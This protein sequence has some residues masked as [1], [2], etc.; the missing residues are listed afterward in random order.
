M[1][2]Q[3]TRFM[4]GNTGVRG[5]RVQLGASWQAVLQ[6][7][8]AGPHGRNLLGQAL[9]AMSLLAA[10]LK[11][12]GHMILQIRGQGPL[13]L[14]VAQA[15]AE[16]T[17][18]GLVRGD[19]PADHSESLNQQFGADHLVITID[20]G[21]QAQPYQGIVPLQ[22]SNLQQAL[23]AY[24]DRSEQLPTQLWL[25]ADEKTAAGFLLQKM[26]GVASDPDGWNRLVTLA[27]SLQSDE[28][29]NL[30]T[31]TLLTRLYHQE[32]VRTFDPEPL[33]FQCGCSRDKSREIIRTL[34]QAEAE[35]I[36]KEQGEIGIHC[37]FCDADYRFDAVDIAELFHVER[38]TNTTPSDSPH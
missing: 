18:R 14:L 12:D 32:E 19:D 26:P 4:V 29:L 20:K 30:P 8:Q 38:W 5:H 33:R 36:L 22:G 16:R 6:H 10:T 34:G 24:F 13:N 15:T 35:D 1:S 21:R 7:S 11:F 27:D 3:I 9:A 37:E 23:Q 28:L 17:L 31:E 2:D 25:R